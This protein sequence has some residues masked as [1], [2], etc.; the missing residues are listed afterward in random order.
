[1]SVYYNALRRLKHAL[2]QEGI[3]ELLISTARGQMINTAMCDCDYYVWQDK[4]MNRRDRFE[5]EFLSEYSWSEYIL[6]NIYNE[7]Y[8]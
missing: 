4:N 2:A 3:S 7:E 6:A 5:G 1:M 8:F